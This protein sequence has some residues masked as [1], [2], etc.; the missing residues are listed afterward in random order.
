MLVPRPATFAPSHNGTSGTLV[1]KQ[2][3]GYVLDPPDE[4]ARSGRV[5]DECSA[6]PG[7]LGLKPLRWPDHRQRPDLARAVRREGQIANRPARRHEIGYLRRS[8]WIQSLMA[9]L[10]VAGI[11]KV[12]GL[13][14]V[15]GVTHGHRPGIPTHQRVVARRVHDHHH[16]HLTSR[17]PIRGCRHRDGTGHLGGDSRVLA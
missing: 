12:H 11:V 2:N 8:F 9:V 3:A 17:G 6:L 1:N 10:T 4:L 16:E 5:A 15:A 14:D 7:T 13:V